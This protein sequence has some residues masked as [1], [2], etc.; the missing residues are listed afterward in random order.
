MIDVANTFER[1]ILLFQTATKTIISTNPNNNI[2][3]D[4]GPSNP[5]ND[6]AQEVIV[7]GLFPARILYDAKQP[8]DQIESVRSKE[9]GQQPNVQI[10]DGYVRIKV[11]SGVA[12]YLTNTK[13]VTFDGSE[14]E[15]RTD[16]RPHGLFT[17][18]YFNFFL[19]RLN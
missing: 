17:A 16:A 6:S 18:Q 12:Q 9:L 14:F 5:I 4:S 13:R 1:N 11:N 10:S 19:K 7:S 15:I 3:F 2:F 8:T